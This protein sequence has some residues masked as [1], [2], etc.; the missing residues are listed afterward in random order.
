MGSRVL[1]SRP[2]K[3]LFRFRRLPLWSD[4]RCTAQ[5]KKKI[6]SFLPRGFSGGREFDSVPLFPQGPKHCNTCTHRLILQAPEQ[7]TVAVFETV[8]LDEMETRCGWWS[9]GH[10]LVCVLE[11]VIVSHCPFTV[12]C[13]RRTPSFEGTNCMFSTYFCMRRTPSFDFSFWGKKVH[14]T[15]RYR[16][17]QQSFAAGGLMPCHVV[18]CPSQ[19]VHVPFTG[20]LGFSLQLP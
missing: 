7:Y 15:V 11:T 16:K 3:A 4:T 6:L 5:F 1:P 20:T 2:I 17:Q 13:I 8:N 18:S 10:F 14:E 19:R 9:A 12:S